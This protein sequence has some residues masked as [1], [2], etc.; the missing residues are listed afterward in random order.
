MSDTMPDHIRAYDAEGEA[1]YREADRR[2]AIMHKHNEPL[3]KLAARLWALAD[4][5]EDEIGEETELTASMKATVVAMEDA[6]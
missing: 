5:I 4:T 6:T 2:A 1:R 3:N